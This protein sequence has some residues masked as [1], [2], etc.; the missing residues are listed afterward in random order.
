[1]QLEVDQSRPLRDSSD[2]QLVS[3]T[4]Q[5]TDQLVAEQSALAFEYR[6]YCIGSE[7]SLGKDSAV[8]SQVPLHTRTAAPEDIAEEPLH[9]H[10][11]S[12]Y[13]AK[14]KCAGSNMFSADDD[15]QGLKM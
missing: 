6:P 12:E 11:L 7:F 4:P 10:F 2:D 13:F 3:V 8:A 14:G 1:L 15:S 9:P 5:A